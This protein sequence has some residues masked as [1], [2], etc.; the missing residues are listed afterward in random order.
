[1]GKFEVVKMKGGSI[2]QLHAGLQTS[3]GEPPHTH[4]RR[5]LLTSLGAVC[6]RKRGGGWGGAGACPP[7]FRSAM[8]AEHCRMR[9]CDEPFETLNYTEMRTCP[10]QEWE[11]V[12]LIR[13]CPKECMR[14]QRRIPVIAELLDLPLARRAAP[15][16]R[17]ARDGLV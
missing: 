8:E 10:K 1:M 2:D 5:R 11:I 7:N 13:P 14:F 15:A 4:R 6:P 9:G 3:I 17:Q 16:A 12:M